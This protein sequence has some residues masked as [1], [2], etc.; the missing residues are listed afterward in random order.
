MS[1]SDF[2]TSLAAAV[3]PMPP[4]QPAHNALSSS[5]TPLDLKVV[6]MGALIV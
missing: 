6:T 4:W 3:E 5:I 2:S 1:K